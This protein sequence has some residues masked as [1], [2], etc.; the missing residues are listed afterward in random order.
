MSV[1]L[2]LRWWA[3]LRPMDG[4]PEQAGRRALVRSAPGGRLGV[5]QRGAGRARPGQAIVE[6]AFFIT[7]LLMLSM[8][9]YE[10]GS[11]F[12]AQI[13]V[14]QAAREG[15]RVA[16]DVAKTSTQIQAAAVT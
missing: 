5:S 2:G 3:R 12:Q 8:G 4:A 9:V 11:A 13:V 16:M 1:R 10:F 7:L 6:L 15:A 14:I